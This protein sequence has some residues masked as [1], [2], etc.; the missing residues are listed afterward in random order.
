MASGTISGPEKGSFGSMLEI[1]WKGTNPFQMSDGSERKFIA[2]GDTVI[3]RGAA[4]KDGLRI[5]FGEV[6]GTLLP[7]F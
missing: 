5:G 4:Q 6:R 3:M 1:S 2:D 7:A